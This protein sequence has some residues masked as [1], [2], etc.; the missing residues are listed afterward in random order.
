M[1]I[2]VFGIPNCDSVRRARQW[3]N[4]AGL[5]HE[6]HDFRKAGLS[7]AHLER[8]CAALGWETLLNRRGTTWRQLPPARREGVDA[9]RARELMLADPTLVKRPVLEIGDRV[10]IGFDA[11]RYQ[12]LFKG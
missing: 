11:D 2:T 1:K 6:F 12:T 9:D 8:W 4:A 3:L 10:E 5:G 7:A